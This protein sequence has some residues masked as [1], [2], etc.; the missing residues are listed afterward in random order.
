MKLSRTELSKKYAIT[1]GQWKNRHDDLLDW[2]NDFFSIEEIKEGRYYYYIIPD[3]ALETI[4][5]LPRKSNKKE[6][7]QDY[8]NY[9]KSHLP[10]DWKPLSKAKM[11][12]D[13]I[14]DFGQ[15]K[16]N[17][18]SIRAVSERYVGPAMDKH[19]EHSDKMVWVNYKTYDLLTEEEENCLHKC[20]KKEHLTELEMANAFK[21]YAQEEDISKEV[22]SYNKAIDKFIERYEF[23]PISVYEWRLKQLRENAAAPSKEEKTG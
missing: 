7:K 14:A 8:E 20:F 4:P 9:T 5:K 10:K 3:D 13:A 15:E 16:Y 18:K 23:R 17:H 21:K 11:S 12:R 19:G 6:K 1:A 22:N 2:I